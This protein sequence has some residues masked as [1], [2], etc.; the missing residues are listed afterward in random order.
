MDVV[1]GKPMV[2]ETYKHRLQRVGPTLVGQMRSVIVGPVPDR[3]DV[4]YVFSARP[5][6]RNERAVYEQ[7]EGR[8]IP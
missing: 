6:S 2:R 5:A 4:Y 1:A 7:E 3:S 8:S